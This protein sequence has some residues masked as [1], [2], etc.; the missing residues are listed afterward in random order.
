MPKRT[1]LT[2]VGPLEIEQRRRLPSCR[3]GVGLIE[4]LIVV[5]IVALLISLLKTPASS[6]GPGA[7]G[8]PSPTSYEGRGF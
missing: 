1:I 5:G 7:P 6:P 2:G 3:N 8:P 4:V